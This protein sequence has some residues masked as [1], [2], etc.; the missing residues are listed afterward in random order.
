MPAGIFTTERVVPSE[1]TFLLHGNVG[2][3]RDLLLDFDRFWG[4]FDDNRE[5]DPER[6]GNKREIGGNERAE[7]RHAVQTQVGKFVRKSAEADS[8]EDKFK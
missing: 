4:R 5:Y 2:W 8:A 1:G 6:A 7:D 3:T